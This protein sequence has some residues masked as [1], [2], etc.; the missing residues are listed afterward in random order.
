MRQKAYHHNP[1]FA[2]A[3]QERTPVVEQREIFNRVMDTNIALLLAAIDHS[4]F[5]GRDD[6][7]RCPALDHGADDVAPYRAHFQRATES[8]WRSPDGWLTTI[9]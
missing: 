9:Q 2:K 5:A 7:V 3:D 4:G 1:A 6:Q 8:A